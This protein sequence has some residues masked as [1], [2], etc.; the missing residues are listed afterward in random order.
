MKTMR[1]LLLLL[2]T[3]ALASCATSR[4]GPAYESAQREMERAAAQRAA[5]E[6]PEAVSQA[7][8]PPL[9]VEMPSVDGR[10]I[11]P[12]FDLEV[13]NAPA[14]QV[15][16][17]IV[18]GT[19]YSMVVHPSVKEPISLNLKDATVFEALEA[20]RE[21]YGYEYRVHGN[22]ILIQQMS[23]Q[24]RVF[25]VNYLLSQRKGQ[26]EV[27]IT[28]GAISDSGAGGVQGPS[29]TPLPGTATSRALESSRVTTTSDNDFWGELAGAVSAMVGT[30][31]GRNVVVSPQAGVI[32]VRAMPAELRSVEEFLRTMS[33]VVERQVMIE[34]KIIEVQLSDEFQ[35]GIN[36]AAFRSGD[37]SRFG[38]GLLTP[39]TTLSPSGS[40]STFTATNPDGT[41]A[42]NSDLTA[43]PGAI[44]GSLQTGIGTPATLL[45]LAFQTSN[46]AALMSF[47]ETQGNLQVLSSPR[48]ATLNNQKAV[49][50]V[51]T[52]E[53]FVTNI[54][55]NTTTAGITTT[56]SPTITVQPFF[57][58]IALDV[59]P[60]ID[61][62]GFITL[63]VHPSVSNVT[64]R[65]K[66]IDLGSAG[67]FR[68]P[69]AS[70][71][72]SETDTIVRVGDGNIVAIGGLMK[73]V[74]VR[75]RSQVPGLGNVPIAGNLFR[76]TNRQTVKSELVILLRPTV[77]HGPSS[78][79]QD[80]LDTRERFDAYPSSDVFRNNQGGSAPAPATR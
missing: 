18:S 4:H 66:N 25:Q 67:Q 63:H 24:T 42:G 48:I 31:E 57:S 80:I 76:N 29:T 73:E 56:Q 62:S 35:T 14:A 13:N 59:T 20:I 17:A 68:L 8:L 60:Q 54:T 43:L 32:V 36:W 46:F 19:R 2:L 16:M 50:K 12:R 27:R 69:L 38:G 64:E 3:T 1:R 33:G 55:T 9:T 26:T 70:S 7:L 74:Q 41:I 52:D 72:I 11:E 49:L 47:L 21:L 30:E 75:G 58:G 10:P 45:G 61:G 78:W 77:I 5:G 15:F 71:N 79:Q 40:I 51:G 28:S 39:G 53:F 22:R 37:N 44:S 23:L 65:T 34:A 6:Q